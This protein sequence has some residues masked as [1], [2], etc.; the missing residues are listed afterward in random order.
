ML[1]SSTPIRALFAAILLLLLGV[2]S[3]RAQE[4]GYTVDVRERGS[5]RIGVTLRVDSLPAGDTLF[6]FAA[7]APGTY[8]TMDIGRFVRDFTALDARG[9]AIS[10]KQ[11]S[12][13]QWRIAEPRRVRVVRYRVHDTWHAPEPEFRVYPMAGTAIEREH[14]L[15]NW[16]AVIGFPVTQQGSRFRVRV[17]RPRDWQVATALREVDGEL[18]ADSY[19][20]LVDSPVLMGRLTTESLCVTGVPVQIAVHSPTSTITATQLA[21]A[22]RDMLQAAGRFLGALPVDRYVFLFDFAPVAEGDATGAWEHAYSSAYTLPEA[23]LTV[24]TGK[25]ITWMAAHEFFHI[26]TPLNLHSELVERFNYQ[27]PVPSRHLWLY[28]GVTE[29]AAQKL[30]LEGGLEPLDAYLT[31]LATK[32]RR[33]RQQYDT[34]YSLTDLART[35][36]T[37]AGARQY[38]NIYQ[39]GALVAGLLDIRLLELSGGTRGLRSLVLDLSRDY[40]PTRPFPE[41]SLID[42]VVSRTHAEIRDFFTRWV[43]GAERLPLREYY[44]K[45]AISVEENERGI[46]TRFVPAVDATPEQMKL[47]EAWLRGGEPPHVGPAANRCADSSAGV[48]R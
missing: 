11:V 47:R 10:T 18:E 8:Q 27:R 45:L 36:Y 33:D 7:T 9:R 21:G 15:L 20:A 14:A 23:P 44:G 26:V 13:N 39:R 25:R 5:H 34:T 37:A 35:S 16:Q 4:L 38:S 17:L 19:D 24:E 2:A 40:G 22:M 30:R 3:L 42:I 31:E 6:Q 29:W 28:E 48:P 43:E 41:D 46:P 12:T 1:P 32:A